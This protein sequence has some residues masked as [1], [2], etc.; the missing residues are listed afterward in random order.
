MTSASIQLKK[1]VGMVSA[2]PLRVFE[3]LDRYI[4]TGEGG[5]ITFVNPGSVREA[6]MNAAYCEDLQSHDLVYADGILLAKFASWYR[7]ENILR[8][9]FDGNSLAPPVFEYCSNN[10]LKVYLVG[11]RQGIALKASEVIRLHFGVRIIGTYTGHINDSDRLALMNSL[12]KLSPDLLVIA[13]GVPQQERFAVELRELG[14]KGVSI[15]CGGYLDQIVSGGV[16]YYPEWI[17]RYNLR[18]FYRL[19]REPRR[20]GR[21][22][23][24]HYSTFYFAILVAAAKRS[25]EFLYKFISARSK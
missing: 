19:V 22:Y 17:N 24:L 25:T 6:T 1:I 8:T 9:S 23:F 10:N 16:Q 13:M 20:L 2:D 11:A 21:R 12:V 18:A 14:W 5:A 15:S 4:K 7:N 3:M